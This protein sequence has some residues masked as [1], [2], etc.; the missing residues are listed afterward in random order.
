MIAA[1]VPG[2]VRA[3]HPTP[4]KIVPVLALEAPDQTIATC[5][6]AG[7]L[8]TNATATRTVKGFALDLPLPMHAGYATETARH[9]RVV[10]ERSTPEKCSMHAG[11]VEGTT[12]PAVVL[13]G[14]ATTWVDAIP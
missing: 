2:D 5:V 9:V 8:D 7:F 13:T 6:R 4:T 3:R 10:T 14:P 11:F 12:R 1:F